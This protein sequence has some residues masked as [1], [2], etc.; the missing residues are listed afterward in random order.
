LKIG[1]RFKRDLIVDL[2]SSHI[3]IA[4][5]NQSQPIR[6]PARIEI[7]SSDSNPPKG[8]KAPGKKKSAK[9]AT[10]RIVRPI[11]G[12]KI[13]DAYA[14]EVILR[15]ALKS[16]RSRLGFFG[17][18]HTALVL[19]APG[20]RESEK[21]M[22]R[23][24]MIDVGFGRARLVESPIAAARGCHLPIEKPEGHMIMDL[25]GGKTT[26]AIFSM[27]EIATW[28]QEPYGGFYL[29]ETVRE[30]VENRY[31]VSI[32]LDQAETIKLQLG[33]VYPRKEPRSMK[34]EL[35]ELKSELPK[36]IQLED[37]EIRDVLVDALEPL[38]H[39]L[40]P[41]FDEV[42]PELAGDIAI[43]GVTLVGGGALLPGLPE[44]FSER[45]GLKFHLAEDPAN[46]AIFGVRGLSGQ[47]LE[48]I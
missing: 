10:S 37:N 23:A 13:V 39:S 24:I 26:M 48:L 45:T 33:S 18:R 11:V 15:E 4:G 36:T 16:L 40:Q 19:A 21:S 42:P 9:V 2:G 47:F 6:S 27:G 28:R 31:R 43:S 20:L 17:L 44:F 3:V 30:Y 46:A 22:L 25:G 1:F 41:V 5:W 35:R 7:Q 38:L 29:S 12:G 8:N 14:L 34:M 32:S